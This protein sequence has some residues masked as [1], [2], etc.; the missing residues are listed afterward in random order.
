MKVSKSP[1]RDLVGR[2]GSF[3]VRRSDKDM[4]FDV[5][6]DLH[7]G[8]VSLEEASKNELVS[9]SVCFMQRLRWSVG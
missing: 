1:P 7:V 9:T 3:R 4:K 2:A 6:G 8:E 5:Q